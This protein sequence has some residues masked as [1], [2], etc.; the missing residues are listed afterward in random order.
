MLPQ[1]LI[2]VQDVEGTS[3]WYQRTLGFTS[4]H[5]GPE[6]E[7]LMSIG[8]MVLQLH[9]WDAHEHPNIGR[10]ELKPYGNGVVLWFL[11]EQVEQAFATATSA[12]A[13]VLEP[14]SVNPNA[15]H[16]EFWLRDPNGYV[17]VVAGQYGQL[18]ATRALTR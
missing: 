16:L 8:Q 9:L 15:N 7:Q 5:G 12:R 10:P 3:A 17:I 14:I 18:G 6:Y 13:E 4:G 11:A 2:A 1:P